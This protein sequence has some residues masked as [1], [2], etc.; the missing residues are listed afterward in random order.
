MANRAR[1][2]GTRRPP[3]WAAQATK[4]QYQLT[5]QSPVEVAVWVHEELYALRYDIHDTLEFGIV[6]S[7]R[8]ERVLPGVILELGP[9]DVWMIPSWEP[10][11]ACT[12]VRDTKLIIVT[13]LPGLFGDEV[14]GDVPWTE[15]MAAPAEERPRVRDDATRAVALQVA[16]ELEAEGVGRPVGWQAMVR[17]HLLRLLLL[18][19]RGW[20]RPAGI[21]ANLSSDNLARITPALEALRADPY[22]RLSL[23]QA[24]DL[25]RMSASHFGRLFRQTMQMSFGRFCLEA[26]V[27][28]A[29]H[30]LAST[31]L[32]I[33][34]LAER[35]GFSDGSHLHRTF[36]RHYGV[37]PST[38]R[39]RFR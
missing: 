28:C 9:G 3:A 34:A 33:G 15:L 5:A 35:L 17:W 6:V 30:D 2:S 39:A 18:L 25:C 14:L 31:D 26:R 8:A 24:A 38:Y 12:T 1:A 22:H 10:H 19:R 4:Y 36:E 23:G 13:F 11:G 20:E 29:A 16:R 32:P 7:G 37:T 27:V 21:R